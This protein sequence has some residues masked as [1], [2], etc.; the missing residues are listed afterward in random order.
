MS[1]PVSVHT[2]DLPLQLVSRAKAKTPALR[3]ARRRYDRLLTSVGLSVGM[4]IISA[5]LVLALSAGLMD[6]LFLSTDAS[7]GAR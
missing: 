4:L 3:S 7:T 2:N 6:G 1:E 5:A